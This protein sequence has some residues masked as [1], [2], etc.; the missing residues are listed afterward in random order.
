MGNPIIL[1][2]ILGIILLV[3]TFYIIANKSSGKTYPADPAAWLQPPAPAEPEL[4]PAATTL[5]DYRQQLSE[6]EQTR[7]LLEQSFFHVCSESGRP[8][9]LRW[10]NCDF[11]DEILFVVEN[12]SLNLHALVPVIISFE[13]IEGGPMEDMDAVGNLRVG[14]ALFV[15]TGENWATRGDV[16]YNLS[17]S[18]TYQHYH[19]NYTPFDPASLTV[20]PPSDADNETLLE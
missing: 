9:G 1:T 17:P 20:R 7:E 10:K 5:P 2:L 3:I 18:E 8:R 6:F 13:A 15:H 16:I 4:P 14:S 11:E 12:H 19:Q